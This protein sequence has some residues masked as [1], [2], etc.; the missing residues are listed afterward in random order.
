MRGPSS[1]GIVCASCGECGEACLGPLA[2]RPL[3][4]GE[5]W[6]SAGVLRRALL[7]R[8]PQQTPQHDCGR[9]RRRLG[10]AWPVRGPSI[11]P[12]FKARES[13]SLI[14]HPLPPGVCLD[15]GGG[16]GVTWSPGRRVAGSPWWPR[17]AG[18]PGESQGGGSTGQVSPARLRLPGRSGAPWASWPDW[19]P[20]ARAPKDAVSCL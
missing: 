6:G 14:P 5:G 7:V 19:A 12:R 11:P 4:A 10:R 13:S 18:R 8:R 2:L 15:W 20:A 1:S 17:G 3:C 9:Q 16:R